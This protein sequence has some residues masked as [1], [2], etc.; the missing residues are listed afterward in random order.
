MA[1]QTKVWTTKTITSDSSAIGKDA[2]ANMIK[3]DIRMRFPE[4]FASMYIKQFEYFT[5]TLHTI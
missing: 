5:K 2:F 3:A 1:N 4:P